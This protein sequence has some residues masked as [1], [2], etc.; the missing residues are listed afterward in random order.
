MM[1]DLRGHYK[2]V[3]SYRAAEYKCVGCGLAKEDNNHVTTCPAYTK[4][5]EDKD[6]SNYQDLVTYFRQVMEA[7]R[8][9]LMS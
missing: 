5:R 2:G 7:R 3:A 8:E 9:I 1:N 4:F 6:L